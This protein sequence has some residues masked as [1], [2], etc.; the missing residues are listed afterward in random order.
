MGTPK[1][2]T[3][4]CRIGEPAARAGAGLDMGPGYLN[5]T[6]RRWPQHVLF[7][8]LLSLAAC[9]GSS[10]SSLPAA[11]ITASAATVAPGAAVTLTWTSTRAQSCQADGQ[12]SGPL[13]LS[14]SKTLYPPT[15]SNDF[16]IECSGPGGHA[17]AHA[18]V[19]VVLPQYTVTK[20]SLYGVSSLNDFGG[21]AGWIGIPP[22]PSTPPGND[23]AAWTSGSAP[24]LAPPPPGQDPLLS[25]CPGG[26][27]GSACTSHANGINSAG[28]VVVSVTGAPS[29]LT[30]IHYG[31]GSA[32]VIPTLLAATA[33]S[34]TGTI[35]GQTLALHAGVFA[36]GPTV[37]LGTFG[38]TTSVA[39][40]I[41]AAGRVVGSAML[42]GDM[43][44]HAFLSDGA[45]LVDLGE[46]GGGRSAAWAV[47]D[48]GVVV[49]DSTTSNGETHAIRYA[50]GQMVDIGASSGIVNSATGIN[51][52]GLIVGTFLPANSPHDSTHLHPLLYSNATTF[53]LWEVAARPKSYPAGEAVWFGNGYVRINNHGQILVPL[54]YGDSGPP[55]HT[56]GCWSV[57][58][59]PP[60][61]L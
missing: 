25:K 40:A 59:T 3:A 19:S 1:R 27:F 12:W 9:G 35:V 7:L 8:A 58:L 33:I 21:V 4:V 30:V 20:I 49:G 31:P 18:A 34:N 55:Y 41:N 47:N 51:N 56:F 24:P 5:S 10:P 53:D 2:S 29:G 32:T 36:S 43:V 44:T 48:T 28:E 46:L 61:G 50:D 6:F 39:N 38:G 14:G 23:E 26:Q 37:D 42:A 15:A 11:A 22:S 17:A 57:L 52:A 45:G 13:A 16:G 60:T 54:C